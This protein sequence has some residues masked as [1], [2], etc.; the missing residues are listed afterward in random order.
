M[1]FDRLSGVA[2]LA[3]LVIV[4]LPF[5]A[6]RFGSGP[7]FVIAATVV[8]SVALGALAFFILPRLRIRWRGLPVHRTLVDLAG[9]ASELIAKPEIVAGVLVLSLL[10]HVSALYLTVVL[11]RAFGAELSVLDALTIVPAVMLLTNLPIS[12][13]GWGVREVGFVGGFALLGL[14]ADAAVGTSILIGMLN[15]FAALPGAAL[16]VLRWGTR[17]SDSRPSVS[18]ERRT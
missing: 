4:G 5:V 1:L 9:C 16:F 11:A 7:P 18:L 17:G 2:A 13:A 14:P 15:L 12:I 3:C 8:G 6:M 10:G